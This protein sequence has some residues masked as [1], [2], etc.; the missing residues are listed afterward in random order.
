MTIDL[1]RDKWPEVVAAVRK[2]R[3]ALGVFLAEGYPRKLQGDVLELAF[4][5]RN[6]FQVD[7]IRRQ[8]ELIRN[9][10][11]GIL[12]RPLRIECVKDEDSEIPTPP[13]TPMAK[14]A[15]L[16]KLAE[17]NPVVRKILDDFEAEL[18]L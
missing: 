8:R 15:A 3:M 16:E 14:Q 4:S 18:L 11:T 10:L 17:E 6:G 13:H 2:K 12:G 9:I 7:S 1:V 5:K